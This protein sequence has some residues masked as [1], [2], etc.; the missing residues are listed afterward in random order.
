MHI[1]II[2]F[3]LN[4]L[5]LEAFEAHVETVA[6]AFALLPG[7]DAKYWLCDAEHNSYG[8]VYL[9]RDRAAMAAYRETGLFAQLTKAH[10]SH[11]SRCATSRSLS[12]QPVLRAA[13]ARR[14]DARGRLAY[15][16]A[17]FRGSKP[18]LSPA[19]AKYFASSRVRLSARCA[20]KPH[21]FKS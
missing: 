6:P 16:V 20:E 9:W 3:Q 21:T 4:D 8:G 7:L 17:S 11:S 18:R 10:T 5:S 15:A 12:A 13:L 14:R 2:T 1:Q 19:A